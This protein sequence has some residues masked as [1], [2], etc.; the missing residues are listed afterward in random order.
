MAE[1]YDEAVVTSSD[2]SLLDWRHFSQALVAATLAAGPPPRLSTP[3]RIALAPVAVESFA[4]GTSA[5]SRSAEGA[6]RLGKKRS[7]ER[8]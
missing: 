5:A 3:T 6:P 1:I 4:D 2:K 7:V 8:D